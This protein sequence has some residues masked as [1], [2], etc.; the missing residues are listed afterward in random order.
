MISIDEGRCTQCGLCVPVCVRRILQS[1]GKIRITDPA[2]CIECGHCKAVCPTNAP[3][4]SNLHE[5]EFEDLPQAD[6]FLPASDFLRFLR[7]RRSLRIYRD[8]PVEVEKLKWIVEAGRFAPTGGNRQACEY[9][10]LRGRR[11]L[12]RVCTLTNQAL[13]EEAKKIREALDRHRR[14]KEPLSEIYV[15]RQVYPPMWERIGQKW[16]EGV[17]QLL[18]HAPALVVIHVKKGAAATAEI[19]TGLAGMQMV[20]MA[21]T[22]G[23]GTCFIGF[24]IFA[25]ENSPDL[26][27]A[28]KIPPDNRAHLA[29]T[30]GYPDVE[31][32]RLVGRRPARVAWL[33]DS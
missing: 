23:L 30:V 5:E 29:F 16:E 27:E 19:D 2:F 10:V 18:Y 24:L 14:L 3:V 26:R 13:A 12:D 8:Q 6:N 17:D 22:L 9:T 1:E 25:L 32:L 33:G 15:S 21:H 31:F 11:I 4:L 20:L 28:L 7:G